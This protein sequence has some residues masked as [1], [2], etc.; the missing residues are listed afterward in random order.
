MNIVQYFVDN[1]TDFFNA[2]IQKFLNQEISLADLTKQLQE[3]LNTIG[4]TTVSMLL[5]HADEMMYRTEKQQH[6]Y[7]VKAKRPRTL[8]TVFG[9]VTYTR[10]YYQRIAD[11]TYHYLLDEWGSVQPYTRVEPYCQAQLVAH[12]ADVSYRKAVA[13]TIPGQL[14]PQSVLHAIRAVGTIPNEAAALPAPQ[15]DIGHVYVEADEDHIAMQRGKTKE[16]KLITVYESKKTVCNGRRKL[17]GKRTFTGFETSSELWKAVNEY[18]GTQY[19]EQGMP[20]VMIKGD[21]A[22]WIQSGTTYVSNSQSVIDGYHA[23]KYLL[24]I[25]GK[26][27]RTALYTALQNNDKAAFTQEVERKSKAS[28]S[29]VKQITEGSA[30][31]LKYWDGIRETMGNPLAASS[32]EGHVSHVLADR[33]SSR[34]MGWS[35]LGAEQVARLRTYAENGGDIQAY[36][37]KKL[38]HQQKKTSIPAIDTEEL[39]KQMQKHLL[40]YCTYIPEQAHWMPGSESTLYGGWMRHIE[41]GGFNHIM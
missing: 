19:G 21:G 29:R 38:T 27:K 30:Y 20:Q 8:V 4:K 11:G 15:A 40:P 31:I 12:T 1:S 10:R 22:R 35:V 37:I 32:T 9:E 39:K 16:M 24:K 6:Q 25:A 3:F 7:H 41:N 28:P 36:A 33:M 2:S 26:G 13:L 14:S 5:E 34:G 17:V 23:S 18:I